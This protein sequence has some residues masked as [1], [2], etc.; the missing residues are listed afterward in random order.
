MS[1]KK[2]SVEGKGRAKQKVEPLLEG[3]RAAENSM[4]LGREHQI[5]F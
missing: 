5:Q 1:S 2:P 3:G 4:A